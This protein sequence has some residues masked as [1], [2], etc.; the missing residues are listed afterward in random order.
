MEKYKRFSFRSSIQ[1]P[2]LIDQVQALVVEL[3]EKS[4]NSLVER[5]LLEGIAKENWRRE[6]SGVTNG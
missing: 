5:F 2:D 6:S 4:F 3:N 1:H